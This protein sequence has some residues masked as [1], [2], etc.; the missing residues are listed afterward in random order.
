VLPLDEEGV[1]AGSRQH[2]RWIETNDISISCPGGSLSPM[3]TV[4]PSRSR[5][6]V[7]G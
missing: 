3:K 1:E 4:G 7:I 6:E 5:S 2:E